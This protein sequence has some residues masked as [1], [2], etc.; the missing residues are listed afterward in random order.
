[1]QR[2]WRLDVLRGLAVLFVVLFHCNEKWYAGSSLRFLIKPFHY[3]GWSGVDLFFVL[4]GF[5]ISGLLFR[6]YQRYGSVSVTRFLIR[7]G[8]KI[9]PTY[10]IWFAV[11]SCG[12]YLAHDPVT[13]RE[14]FYNLIY[15][16]V[17][18]HANRFPLTW[19]LC[20]EEHFYFMMAFA[21]AAALAWRRPGRDAFDGLPGIAV[22]LSLLPLAMRVIRVLKHPDVPHWSGQMPTHLRYDELFVGVVLGYY[23][24][25]HRE[26]FIAFVRRWRYTVA[27]VS[28]AFLIVRFA[29]VLPTVWWYGPGYA[30]LGWAYG[31][32]VALVVAAPPP[33]EGPPARVWGWLAAIGKISYSM[34]LFEYVPLGVLAAVFPLA[35]VQQLSAEARAWLVVV[36]YLTGTWAISYAAWWLIERPALALRDR[37]YPSRSSPLNAPPEAPSAAPAA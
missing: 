36:T 12:A 20:I 4:S 16:Q 21:A 32:V 7:R 6:E 27:L 10:Y 18:A 9:Y 34:Y 26:R 35:A 28:V 3:F 22:A 29:D 31:G 13:L 37:W 1:M 23:H 24:A 30:M 5:L 15:F 33:A 8:F 11:V 14:V 19:T 17:Y 25:F 2:A